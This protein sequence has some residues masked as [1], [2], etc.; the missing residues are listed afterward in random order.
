MEKIRRAFSAIPYSPKQDVSVETKVE[1]TESFQYANDHERDALSA[2]LDAYRQY[3]HKFQNLLKR[4]PPGHDLDEVRARVIRG[5]SLE[6]VLGDMKVPALYR[7]PRHRL[8]R[9]MENMMNAS[10]YSTGW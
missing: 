4:I 7:K 1:L 10:V 5:Q 9:S 2:A 6:H 8:H 3:R